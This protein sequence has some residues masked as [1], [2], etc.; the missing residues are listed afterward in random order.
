MSK[1]IQH[2]GKQNADTLFNELSRLI[3]QSQARL[4]SYANSTV[5]ALFWQVGKR[6]NEHIL[7]NKR[8]G[9]GKEIVSTLSTQLKQQYGKNFEERNLRRM[10][11]FTEQFPDFEIVVPLARQL[12]WSHFVEFL[13]LKKED[14]RLFYAQQSIAENWGIRQLREQIGSKAYERAGIANTQLKTGSLLPFNTFKDPYILDFL[15]LKDGYLEK[16]L[17]AAIL[18]DL[19]RFILEIGKGFAFVERQKR[20]II[21]GEDYHLDLLFFHRKLKRLV[22]IDLKIGKFQ[23]KDKGQMELYLKWLHRYEMQEGEEKPIGPI[24]CAETSREQVELLEM[25]KDGIMI[26]E[27]WTELPPK[28]ELEKHLHKALMEAREMLERKKL[29]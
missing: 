10:M 16:D 6:I 19:E 3:E 23:A 8:A 14:A 28:K 7:Q 25:H 2:S 18:K 1:K 21:D 15:G 9:Y 13:P 24:L 4:Q 26:A 27:Y 17:E 5:T 12:S 20:M 22:A 11:Q 29:M